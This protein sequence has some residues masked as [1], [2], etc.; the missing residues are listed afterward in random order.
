[1]ESKYTKSLKH[2]KDRA[3]TKSLSTNLG[4]KCRKVLQMWSMSYSMTEIAEAVG[5]SN[6][7]VAMNKKN[8]CMKQFSL[9]VKDEH[10]SSPFW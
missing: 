2:N 1:M 8:A 6:A 3:V 10:K 7:Q 4:E 5:Y 9:M